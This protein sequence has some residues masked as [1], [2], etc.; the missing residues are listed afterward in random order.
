MLQ[1]P[2]HNSKA[3]IKHGMKYIGIPVISPLHLP[4]HPSLDASNYKCLAK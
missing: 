4:P 2:S 1:Y 3:V